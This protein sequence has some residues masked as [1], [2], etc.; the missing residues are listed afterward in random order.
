MA[1]SRVVKRA[2]VVQL[3]IAGQFLMKGPG[4]Y[5]HMVVLHVS[6]YCIFH[7]DATSIQRVGAGSCPWVCREEDFQVCVLLDSLYGA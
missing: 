5:C 3:I 7:V 2:P 6:R 1:P 4:L